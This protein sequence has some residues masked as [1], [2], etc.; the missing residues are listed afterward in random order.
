MLILFQQTHHIRVAVLCL[1]GH[2]IDFLHR[3]RP[4]CRKPIQRLLPLVDVASRQP[5]YVVPEQRQGVQRPKPR[6]VGTGGGSYLKKKGNVF[7]I[8]VRC[9]Y[10]L[11]K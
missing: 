4:D 11:K 5:R 8:S 1:I 7:A 3:R 6:L 10:G 9:V 2:L